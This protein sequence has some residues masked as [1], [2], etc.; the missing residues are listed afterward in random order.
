[1]DEHSGKHKEYEKLKKQFGPRPA[2]N[3]LISKNFYYFGDEAI[4]LPKQLNHLIID[5]QGYWLVDD[6]DI[7]ILKNHL[8]KK[9]KKGKIGKPNNPFEKVKCGVCNTSK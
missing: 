2:T 9:G 5:R 7:K 1:M 8:S 6:K 4:N 3:V